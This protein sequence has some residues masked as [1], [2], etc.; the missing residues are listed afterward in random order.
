MPNLVRLFEYPKFLRDVDG[1]ANSGGS[2]LL[3][4]TLLIWA[5][6]CLPICFFIKFSASYERVDCPRHLH[7]IR[8]KFSTS[9]NLKFPADKIFHAPTRKYRPTPQSLC[10]WGSDIHLLISSSGQDILLDVIT[11]IYYYPKHVTIHILTYLVRLFQ[12]L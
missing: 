3:P 9:R 1:W 10:I 6:L 11:I 4:C 7:P 8:C 12:M 2:G 5:L